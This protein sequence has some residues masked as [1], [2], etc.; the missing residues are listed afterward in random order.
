MAAAAA[1]KKR[2][3]NRIDGQ[4]TPDNRDRDE[5]LDHISRLPDE[6]LGTIISLLPTKDGARTQAVARRWRHLWRSAPLNLQVDY[7]LS[8]QD[9]K[10]VIFVT[11]ILADHPGP[12]RRFSLR[13]IFLRDRYSKIDGWLLSRTLNGLREIE[14]SYE[15]ENR[16]LPYPLPPS[17]LRFAPTLCVADIGSCDFP[18]EI[19]PSLNFPC[20]KQLTLR[21]VSMSEDAFHSL[22]S[23]CPVLESLLLLNN[24]GIVSLRISSPT[25]RSIGFS[26]AQYCFRFNVQ[27][28][29]MLQELVIEHAPC[30]E[31]L[32][33]LYPN[34]GPAA[35]RVMHAPKLEILGL[36][37][38]G[39]SRL[40]LGTSVFQEMMAV[41]LTSSMCTVKI[42]VL[43]TKGPN[44][45]AV[46]NF[47][48]CFPCLEKLYIISHPMKTMKNVLRYNPL[49][50]IK[51]LELH[52]EKVVLKNYDG[53]KPDVDFAK[54]FVLN[55]KALKKMEF[56]VLNNCNDKWLANQH[57]RLQL[58]NRASHGAEF[59]FKSQYSTLFT[60]NKH[61]HDL[62]MADPFDSSLCRCCPRI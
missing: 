3:P 1:A 46:V 35:I 6:V 54:F 58:D 13:G 16:L 43:D 48:M 50:P 24:A 23:G 33:P 26:N 29:I 4:D 30:L 32:L 14:F 21:S 15:I 28:A 59:Q 10:R 60:N 42:L 38:D 5:M 17:A 7:H 31:R 20:L 49:H 53:K 22:L 45:D 55:A 19:A 25:L 9:R 37:S 40:E 44:L 34:H 2:K 12:A 57:R 41:S 62:W 56:G 36:L 47:I 51:C 27:D 61:T 18:N 39:I 8:G 11:K 52:L